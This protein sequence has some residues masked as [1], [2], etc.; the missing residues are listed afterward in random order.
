MKLRRTE[1]AWRLVVCGMIFMRCF[2]KVISCL[3]C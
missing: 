3:K 2:M 1:A